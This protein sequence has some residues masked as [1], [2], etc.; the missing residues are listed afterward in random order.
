M[1]SPTRPD[2]GA[3]TPSRARAGMAFARIPWVVT[4]QK[5]ANYEANY[6]E[7]V[8]CNP[9]A[10][11]FTVDLPTAKGAKDQQ[12]AI[13]NDSASVNGI[14]LEPFG[15]ELI[16]G[17]SNYLMNIARQSVT[18]VSTGTGWIIT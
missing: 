6:N 3:G 10:G 2:R 17:A 9:T 14:T 7:L 18:L 15:D 12:I 11:A 16:D 1:P 4:D 5:T 8:R 13:K